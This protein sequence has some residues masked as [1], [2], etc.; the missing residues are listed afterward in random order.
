MKTFGFHSASVTM[1]GIGLRRL[2]TSVNSNITAQEA[3]VIVG[4][5]DSNT[6]FPDRQKH[7]AI[8]FGQMEFEILYCHILKEPLTNTSI[9][10]Y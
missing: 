5:T 3:N 2:L 7:L 1:A 8:F 4:Y 6:L 10:L 9:C